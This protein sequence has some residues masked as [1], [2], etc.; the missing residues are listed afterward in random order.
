MTEKK[1]GNILWYTAPLFQAGGGERLLFEGLNWLNKNG[2]NA[3]LI[4]DGVNIA[5]EHFFGKSELPFKVHVLSEKQHKNIFTKYFEICRMIK[6]LKPDIIIANSQAEAAKLYLFRFIFPGFNYKYVCFIHGSFF[7]FSDDYEK[8][9]L[10]FKKHL[11]E[12][13]LNDP[14][15]TQQIPE[16][17]PSLKLISRIKKELT[18]FVKFNAVHH[19]EAIFVLTA[20]AKREIEI[21]YDHGKVFSAKGAFSESEIEIKNGFNDL[22]SKY[23]SVGKKVIFSLCRLV[24]KKRVDFIIRSFALLCESDADTVLWIGGNGPHKNELIRIADELGIRNRIHFIGFV[25][26]NEIIDHYMSADAFICADIADYDITTHFALA[27]GRKVI[28][29]SQHDFETSADQLQLLFKFENSHEHASAKMK[30]ALNSSHPVSETA[31][32]N[33]VKNHSWESYFKKLYDVM[34]IVS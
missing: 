10:P 1:V 28:V 25:A 24:P 19:S 8:Y 21:L 20:K 18:S 7:Q 23:G 13:R 34:N 22:K 27:L 33:F 2:I 16:E 32:Q 5:P 29:S 30:D 14:V 6:K 11:N 15:Y 9:M 26:D 12:I 17:I 4:A 3:S 31:L